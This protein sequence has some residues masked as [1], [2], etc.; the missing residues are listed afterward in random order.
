MYLFFYHEKCDGLQ[1]GHCKLVEFIKIGEPTKESATTDQ[2]EYT[3]V[4]QLC[5]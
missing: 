5:R 4:L 1:Y 2:K 3:S